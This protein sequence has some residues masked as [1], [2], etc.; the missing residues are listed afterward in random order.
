MKYKNGKDVKVGDTVALLGRGRVTA[1]QPNENGIE[2]TFIAIQ[3]ENTHL[4]VNGKASDFA[5]VDD[6]TL[7][8]KAPPAP[9]PVEKAKP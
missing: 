3:P 5:L 6:T 2:G 7:T 4:P 9:A 1:L 8:V